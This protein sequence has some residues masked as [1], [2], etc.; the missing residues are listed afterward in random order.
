MPCYEPSPERTLDL[1][2]TV[3]SAPSGPDAVLAKMPM[4]KVDVRLTCSPYTL[5]VIKVERADGQPFGLESAFEEW[6]ADNHCEGDAD[7]KTWARE[8]FTYGVKY[9]K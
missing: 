2:V 3:V 4:G 8:A 1:R 9:G 7:E 6:W 5:K